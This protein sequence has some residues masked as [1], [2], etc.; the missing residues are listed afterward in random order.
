LAAFRTQRSWSISLQPIAIGRKNRV[1]GPT[2]CFQVIRIAK[3][4]AEA[5]F[6]IL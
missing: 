4:Q 2:T 5:A 6:L 1:I 3:I